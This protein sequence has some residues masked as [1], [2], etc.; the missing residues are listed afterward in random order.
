MSE[1][2][3]HAK[4][5]LRVA[6]GLIL[7]PDGMLLLGQRPQG[8]PWEGWWELPGGKI[9]AGETVL[10]ALARE[11]HE[12]LG[13]TVSQSTR[14]VTYVHEYPKNIVELHFC[15]VT[16]WEGQPSGRENQ[17]LAWVDPAQDIAVGPLLPAAEPPLRWLRLP[18]RYLIT[19]LQSPERQAQGLAQLAQRLESGV[20]LVQFRESEW[21]EGA[22]ADSLHAALL[23]V[24]A[25]CQRHQARC[26][27]NSRHPLEWAEQA[28]GLHLRASDV[29]AAHTWQRPPGL[30]AVSVHNAGEIRAAQ[31]LDPDFMVLGHVLATPSHP[32]AP[33][34]G[35]ETFG[36]LAEQAGCPV[37]A[38]GGQS[39]AT[40]EA[41]RAHGAHGIAGMRQM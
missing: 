35:W 18:D 33:P 24:L 13:I 32:D 4:P 41:A 11:L 6:A 7:Q 8:K 19:Q 37:F 15:R 14:W 17:A 28:D 1:A 25:L 30:L 40:L 10:Q 20:R 23:D 26:L 22:A 2:P 3:H 12:E 5:Y 9:E 34:M 38:L 39:T 36:Q 31:S 21:P 27:V 16:A 29:P